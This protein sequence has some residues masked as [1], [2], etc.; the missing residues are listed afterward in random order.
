MLQSSPYWD[1]ESDTTPEIGE[2]LRRTT[3]NPMRPNPNPSPPSFLGPI[4]IARPPCSCLIVAFELEKKSIRGLG[5]NIASTYQA[6]RFN[7]GCHQ[8]SKMTLTV[9]GRADRTMPVWK[10]IRSYRYRSPDGSERCYTECK[11]DMQ[12]VTRLVGKLPMLLRRRPII[13][14]QELVKSSG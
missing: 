13:P 11:R 7:T 4:L 5:S 10:Y 8:V 2:T 1:I 6:A 14:L 3:S 12:G 9:S